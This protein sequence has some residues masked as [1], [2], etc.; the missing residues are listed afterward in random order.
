MPLISRK[1]T[2][3][4]TRGGECYNLSDEMFRKEFV[5]TYSLRGEPDPLGTTPYWN[6][7]MGDRAEA[8]SDVH[9]AN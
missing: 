3:P 4:A 8:G 6:C 5:K 1:A 7:S 2:L 9:P